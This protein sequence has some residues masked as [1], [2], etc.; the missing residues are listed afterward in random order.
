[1]SKFKEGERVRIKQNLREID[2][3]VGL[4]TV[5]TPTD[6]RKL[7]R[8]VQVIE[9]VYGYHNRFGGQVYQVCGYTFKEI[10]LERLKKTN[11]RRN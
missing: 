7:E 5:G 10:M 2:N 1:M 6:M 9:S 8:T 3:N 4:K 11:I